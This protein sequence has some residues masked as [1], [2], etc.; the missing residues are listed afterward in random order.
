[1]SKICSQCG[2]ELPEEASF[3]PY[4]EQPQLSAETAAPPR[5]WRRRTALA[6]G[7]LL[8]ALLAALALYAALRPRVFDAQGPELEYKG[9]HVLLTFSMKGTPRE[10]EALR[11]STIPSHANYA[12]P[13]QLFVYRNHDAENA[14]DAFLSQ[15]SHISLTTVPHDGAT[16]MEYDEPA[17]D[18]VFPE[19]ARISNIYYDSTCGTNDI[20]W[21]ITMKNGDRLILRH[22]IA[23]FP[24][25]EKSYYS[26]DYDM[27]SL[28]ALNALLREIETTEEPE[29]LVSIYLPPVVYDGG[30]TLSK[31][32]YYFYGSSDG[33]VST[34]FTGTVTVEVETPQNSEFIGVTFAGQGGIGLF[35]ARSAILRQCTLTGWD[36]GAVASNGAWLNVLNCRFA[37]NG[38]G[39]QYNTATSKL[40]GAEIPNCVFENNGIGVHFAEVPPE[41]HAMAFANCSFRG[42]G[43]DIQN[44]TPLLPETDTSTFE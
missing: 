32:G 20:L 18:E 10:A 11:N 39:L 12:F 14:K 25:A 23:V 42:N 19:A 4:C 34:T 9:Y 16:Q 43:T 24:Q 7:I 35:A 6:V 33:T 26:T 1:M 2:R 13:S 22:S 31:R 3:C 17:P 5:R 29:T 38:I 8:A 44:D 15:V 36:T 40:R 30:L 21:T 37:D 28:E 27:S 41:T